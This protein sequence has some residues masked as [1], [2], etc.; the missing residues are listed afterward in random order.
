MRLGVYLQDQNRHVRFYISTHIRQ[1]RE[2]LGISAEE[3]A[4]KLGINLLSYNKIESGRLRMNEALFESLVLI[5]KVR[6]EDLFE[7]CKIA[8]IAY[9]NALSK[10]LSPNYPL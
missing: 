5:L 7:L 10:E 1:K 8:N 9:A 3:V 2:S 6:E 4:S